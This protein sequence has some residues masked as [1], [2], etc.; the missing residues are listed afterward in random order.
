MRLRIGNIYNKKILCFL[1]LAAFFKP[2]MLQY[3]SNL[4]IFDSIWNIYKLIILLLIIGN[5]FIFDRG[6]LNKLYFL[7]FLFAFWS[8]IVT[9]YFNG[10][11]VRSSI[12]LLT[13]YSLF[14][15][16]SKY[17]KK[18]HIL[19]LK[20]FSVVLLI[21][22]IGQL[23]S[24]II[25]PNGI[26]AD[27]YLN[28][29]SNPLFFMTIDNGTASLTLTNCIIAI[30]MNYNGIVNKIKF[31]III[32]I[33]IL[34]A[35][36]SGST[37]ATVCV[38]SFLLIVL[39]LNLQKA[40]IITDKP[41]FWV[42]IYL[43]IFSLTVLG[44][45]NSIAS[46]FFYSVTGKKGFTGRTYLWDQAFRKILKSPIIGYGRQFKDYLKVWGGYFSSHNVLLEATLQ[47][48]IVE[49]VLYLLNIIYDTS[50]ARFIRNK[51]IRI[52]LISAVFIELIALMMEINVFSPYLFV[53]LSII[54]CG[55]KFES[56]S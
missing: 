55:E 13:I 8:L 35:I 53:L 22:T 51:K 12:D 33:S 2:N 27:L 17:Y 7:V 3:S 37:T 21:C 9:V 14:V 52:T 43:T 34:T 5:H 49:T 23:I 39:F 38:I 16:V 4:R 28:N 46:S 19:F 42:V 25:F 26:P 30:L 45:T 11:I 40:N 32:F 29:T 10:D 6:K 41:L 48:G 24:E 36:L 20:I 15:F 54:G 56:I 31:Y 47:G 44:G 50:F 18:N 1:F